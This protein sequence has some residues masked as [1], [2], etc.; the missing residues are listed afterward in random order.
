MSENFLSLKIEFHKIGTRSAMSFDLQ[1][2]MSGW[3]P[4]QL[5]EPSSTS[6]ASKAALPE[7][8]FDFRLPFWHSH[9][10]SPVEPAGHGCKRSN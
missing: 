6:E 10:A 5:G 8:S 9:R 2:L 3:R 7:T 4:F 1:S